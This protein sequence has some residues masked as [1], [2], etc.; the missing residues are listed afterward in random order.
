M[1]LSLETTV[2]CTYTTC[3]TLKIQ[4]KA[5]YFGS[6]LI[7]R[8]KRSAIFPFCVLSTYLL[9]PTDLLTFVLTLS[10]R[11]L[12]DYLFT[13]LLTFE[14]THILP[15]SV[16]IFA[17]LYISV[18]IYLLYTLIYFFYKERLYKI[19]LPQDFIH[20]SVPSEPL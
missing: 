14:L 19:F 1:S 5:D 18:L 6:I 11:V 8:Y 12:S 4:N 2:Y 17:C 10:I 15:N 3:T 16:Q 20:N 13:Y 7:C 9:S